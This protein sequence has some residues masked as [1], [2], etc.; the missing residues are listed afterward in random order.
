MMMEYMK[1]EWM[2]VVEYDDKLMI[3]SLNEI[4]LKLQFYILIDNDKQ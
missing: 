3:G 2:I 4:L 1:M